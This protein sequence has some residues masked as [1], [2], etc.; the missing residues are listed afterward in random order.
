MW[1]PSTPG[2]SAA[3]AA[4]AMMALGVDRGEIVTVNASGREAALALAA[5]AGLLEPVAE[6]VRAPLVPARAG[7][8]P[9][10]AAGAR[11]AGIVAVRGLATGVAAPQMSDDPPVGEAQGDR[12]SEGARLSAA[13]GSVA[14]FVGDLAAAG[15][16]VRRGVLEAH[17]ALLGDPRLL[18]D[19]QAQL[20]LGA[21]AGAA[22]RSALRSAATAL[23]ALDDPRMAE[24]R[25]DLLDIERQ[26]LRVLNGAAADAAAELPERAIVLATEL[27][28]SQL[29][30]L[31]ATRL[32]GLCMA[33]G[34]ATSHVAIL[35]AAMGL[36]TVVAAGDAMQA[37]VAG[38]LLVLDAEAGFLLVN[39]PAVE[40]RRVEALVA[41]RARGVAI[42]AHGIVHVVIGPEAPQV[43]AALRAL[44]G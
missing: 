40:R 3:I 38:T 6:P 25:A 28:P 21:S 5:L 42:T 35:A 4:V 44:L 13:V 32:V 18:R 19:A 1:M 36:P 31:D 16:G 8:L 30:A 7:P 14:A 17:L 34:G 43:A 24:R 23:A 39:P 37:I 29:L 2:T 11:V 33:E 9:A 26:V 15:E 20:V 12:A 10:P 27:L 41:E 22:W